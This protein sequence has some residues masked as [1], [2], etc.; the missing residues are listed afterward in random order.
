MN[1][2]YERLV[3]NY[4]G[5][6]ARAIAPAPAQARALVESNAAASPFFTVRKS[7]GGGFPSSEMGRGP[8]SRTPFLSNQ[9]SLCGRLTGTA[10]A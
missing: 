2:D 9:P 3:P 8:A 1:S 4:E 10:R 6:L 5:Y 7:G